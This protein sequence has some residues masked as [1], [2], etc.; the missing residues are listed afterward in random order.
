MNVLPSTAASSSTRPRSRG[1]SRRAA[2]SAWSVSGTSSRLDRSGGRVL[3]RPREPRAPVE[4]H[5]RPS[6]PRRAGCPRL[7]RGSA[8]AAPPGARA[9]AREQLV[10]RLGAAAA[11]G[12][13]S[14]SCG[15]PVPHVGPAVAELGPRQRQ[16]EDRVVS[17]PLEQV[18][19]EVEQRRR[20]P[21]AGPRRRALSVPRSAIRSKNS[22]PG[23]E[24]LLAAV[25]ASARRGPSRSGQP[26]LD[27]A[28]APRGRA[29]CSSSACGELRP[30]A[31]LVGSSS[32]IPARIRTISAERPERDALAVGEAAA[33][34]PT[35]VVD[36]PVEVL[37]EL[38]GE[39]A[40]CRCRPIPS[41]RDEPRLALVRGGVEE[42]LEQAE[43]A[44][45]SDERRLE[46]SRAT[47]AAVARQRPGRRARAA[48]GSVLPLS[49]VRARVL[50]GDRGA[51]SRVAS[52]RRR[53]TVPGQATDCTREAVFT[54]SPATIPWPSAPTVTAASPVR[55]PARAVSPAAGLARSAA[56]ASTSSSAARTARSA[57]SSGRPG[58]PRRPSPRRR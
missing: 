30:V 10:H 48:T 51:R 42:V 21:T 56:T 24:Q 40:T 5:P 3:R 57:S 45:A 43:L 25:G 41:D 4:Q 16:H 44:V 27:P 15:R 36:E 2:I 13:A 18:L 23:R 58:R 1:A 32:A 7:R 53:S 52:R 28:P 22:A 17:G 39:P 54:R 46:A 12:R 26:R 38:P 33:A 8:A 50:E 9:P 19:D 35:D 34:V 6:R 29:R 47:L 11:P 20:R 49:L 14:G 55:T 37:L 31:E